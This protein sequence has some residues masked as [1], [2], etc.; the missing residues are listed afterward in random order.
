MSDLESSVAQEVA[1]L[2]AGMQHWYS[3][4]KE[5]S[6]LHDSVLA[7]LDDDFRIVS[8][9]GD[10]STRAQLEVSFGAAGGY[11]AL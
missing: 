10:E 6:E 8:A 1:A 2:A 9:R 5:S 3:A 7:R 4:G 11:V